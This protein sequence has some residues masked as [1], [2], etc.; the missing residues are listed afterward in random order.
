[1]RKIP[2]SARA[3]IDLI[4]IWVYTFEERDEAQAD[5]Y[6]AA[7]N[8]AIDSLAINAYRGVQRS[9][10]RDGYRALFVNR[11]AIYY[12]VTPTGVE[13]VRVLHGQM[14]AEAHLGDFEGSKSPRT[15]TESFFTTFKGYAKADDGTRSHGDY[16]APAVRRRCSFARSVSWASSCV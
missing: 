13:V 16:R 3:E 6:Q 4:E 11:Y 1:M 5:K 14:D 10:V 2:L 12:T 9:N 8:A 7:L 15:F